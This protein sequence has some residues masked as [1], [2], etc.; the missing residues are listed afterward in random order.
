MTDPTFDAAKATIDEACAVMKSQAQTIDNLR[1]RCARLTAALSALVD[2]FDS[3]Y[4][5]DPITHEL[6]EA[7]SD[8]RYLAKNV[9]TDPHRGAR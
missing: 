4:D 8:A 9:A 7:L 6:D 5:G 1:A 2:G 3:I